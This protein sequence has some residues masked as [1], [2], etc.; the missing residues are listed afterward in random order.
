[1]LKGKKIGFIN[2]G[3]DDYYAQ[4]GKT[5]K[6]VAATYGMDVT[7]LNSDYK[8]EKEL[9]NT[10][11]LIAK[12]VDAIAVITAGAAGSAASIKAASD[13]KVPIFFIA[14]KPEVQA[15]SDY[16]GHVTDNFA[17]MGYRIGQWVATNYPGAQSAEIPGFLG[18]GPAEGEIVGYQLAM[19]EAKMPPVIM[20]KAAD[21]Q[22]VKAVPVV[23]DL[24]ASGKP[25]KVIFAANEEEARGVIQVFREQGITDKVIVSNNGKEDAWQWMKDGTM[26]ATVP[27]PPSLNADLCVQQIAAV[28]S[29][30]EIVKD[31]QIMPFAVL[32]KD[33]LDQAI[34]WDTDTYMTGRAANSFKWNLDY[35]ETQYKANKDMFDRFDTK[36]AEYMKAE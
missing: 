12:G 5:L 2:A 31:L 13:A 34:P 18:Q 24:L 7:E 21:W 11:D 3:P 35:Y 32:T 36:I 4:F 30:K 27:N 9:A 8:P 20:L 33:N 19:D 6:A 14:G 22:S 10:H 29:G 16:T 26:A 28:L 15:G 17:I 23:E 25:F 1:M